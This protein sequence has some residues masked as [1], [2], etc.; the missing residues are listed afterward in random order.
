M[1]TQRKPDQLGG[2]ISANATGVCEAAAGGLLEHGNF[3]IILIFQFIKS[4]IL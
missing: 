4:S 2:A 3:Y 1:L